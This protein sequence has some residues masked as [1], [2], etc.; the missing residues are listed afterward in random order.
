M[1]KDS[2]TVLFE[3][4]IIRIHPVGH[5]EHTRYRFTGIGY[6]HPHLPDLVQFISTD[7]QEVSADETWGRSRSRVYSLARHLRREEFTEEL[8]AE[9]KEILLRAL[10]HPFEVQWISVEEWRAVANAEQAAG[11]DDVQ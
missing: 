10:R 4:S 2:V 8:A 1:K 7:V 9:I 6:G 5:P 3:W 11:G